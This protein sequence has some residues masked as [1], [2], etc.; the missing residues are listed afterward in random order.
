MENQAQTSVS[1]TPSRSRTPLLENPILDDETNPWKGKQLVFADPKRGCENAW[2]CTPTSCSSTPAKSRRQFL[3]GTLPC[4]RKRAGRKLLASSSDIEVGRLL[5]SGGGGSNIQAMDHDS[6]PPSK[7]IACLFPTPCTSSSQHAKL[8]TLASEN[9]ALEQD[10]NFWR[11]HNVQ[12]IVRIRPLN[13]AETAANGTSTCLRQESPHALTWLGQ[14]ESRFTFDHVACASTSQEQ[15]FQLA[16]LPMVENCIK[17]YNSTIFAY[18]QT[19]SGKT[20]TMLGDIE[21]SDQKLSSDCG[22]TPRIFEYL[23]SRVEM[24]EASCRQDQLIFTCKCSFLEIYNEQITDL[25][26]P[27]STNLQIHENPKKGVYVENLK[28]IEVKNVGDITNLLLQGAANR[29]VAQTRM[30]QESSRSH[31]VFTCVIES[32]WVS[33]SVTN[34]RFGRLNLVDLAGSER[35]KASGAEGERLREAAN[36]N[37]SLSTLGLVIMILVDVA[38]GKQRHVPYRDSKLTFLLQDSL[39]GNSKTTIIATVSPAVSCAN[40]TLSTL[41]FAQRAKFIQNNAIINEDASGDVKALQLQIQDLKKELKRLQDQT[42]KSVPVAPMQDTQASGSRNDVQTIEGIHLEYPKGAEQENHELAAVNGQLNCMLEA[43][44]RDLEYA[45]TM[46]QLKEDKIQRLKRVE[47]AVLSAEN[48]LQEENRALQQEVHLLKERMNQQP[49]L[50][51]FAFENKQLIQQLRSQDELHGKEREMLMGELS[52]LRRQALQGNAM[53]SIHKEQTNSYTQNVVQMKQS[54]QTANSK[55][56]VEENKLMSDENSQA[57]NIIKS[58]IESQG[59]QMDINCLL[60]EG[61]QALDEALQQLQSITKHSFN[62]SENRPISFIHPDIIHRDDQEI[63]CFLQQAFETAKEIESQFKVWCGVAVGEHKRKR[64]ESMKTLPPNWGGKRMRALKSDASDKASE[65]QRENR[66]SCSLPSLTKNC[67]PFEENCEFKGTLKPHE[68]SI[69]ERLPT[70]HANENPS[71]TKE[72]QNGQNSFNFSINVL[73]EWHKT[74]GKKLSN[75]RNKRNIVLDA[76]AMPYSSEAE[77]KQ[78]AHSHSILQIELALASMQELLHIGR[79]ERST[80]NE[81]DEQVFEQLERQLVYM[82]QMLEDEGQQF[83]ALCTLTEKLQARIKQ[84]KSQ[85]V[86]LKRQV[87]KLQ[88][89]AVAKENEIYALQKEERTLAT[90]VEKLHKE[91]E[92]LTT[93]LLCLSQQLECSEKQRLQGEQIYKQTLRGIEENQFQV[94]LKLQKVTAEIKEGNDKFMVV[95]K[96]MKATL[97]DLRMAENTKQILE[98]AYICTKESKGD[99]VSLENGLAVVYQLTSQ[100]QKQLLAMEAEMMSIMPLLEGRLKVITDAW[101]EEKATI[102]VE[103]DKTRLDA[104][105]KIGEASETLERFKHG[106]VIIRE[107]ELMV[108]TLTKAIESAR[109]KQL[110]L[111][112]QWHAERESMCAEIAELKRLVAQKEE[113]LQ[114]KEKALISNNTIMK[115]FDLTEVQSSV[116]EQGERT[117]STPAGNMVD[118]SECGFKD[119]CQ[120]NKEL[121]ARKGDAYAKDSKQMLAEK[122]ELI[123]LKEERCP[124]KSNIRL[125]ETSLHSYESAKAFGRIKNS[126]MVQQIQLDVAAEIPLQLQRYDED[127]NMLLEKL[128]GIV[129]T[130]SQKQGGE[131]AWGRFLNSFAVALSKLEED[132][133]SCLSFSSVICETLDKT[134]A[135]KQDLQE[136][137]KR[138]Q[139]LLKGSFFDLSLLQ[140]SIADY[141]NMKNKLDS[142]Q[143]ELEIKDEKLQKMESD[144]AMLENEQVESTKKAISLEVIILEAEQSRTSMAKKN[145]EMR[146]KMEV[147]DEKIASLKAMLEEQ[148]QANEKLQLEMLDMDFLIEQKMTDSFDNMKEALGLAFDEKQQLKVRLANAEKQLKTA[149]LAADRSKRLADE[150]QQIAETSMRCIEENASELN[151]MERSIHEFERT[152]SVLESQIEILKTEA[153][154]QQLRREDLEMELQALRHQQYHDPLSSS[155]TQGQ[156][157]AEVITLR[158]ELAEKSIEIK[159]LVVQVEELMLAAERQA[160]AHHQKL[161]SLEAMA[162]NLNQERGHLRMASPTTKNAGERHVGNCSTSPFKCINS[163][164]AQQISYEKDEELYL[165]KYRIDELQ[166]LAASRQKE[167]FRLHRKLAEAEAMT[168]DVIRDLLGVK[169]DIATHASLLNHEDVETLIKRASFH[170]RTAKDKEKELEALR[171]EY[172]EEK[173]RW[174]KES[175]RKQAEVLAAHFA[176]EKLRQKEFLLK[177]ENKRLKTD[178]CKQKKR[179]LRLQEKIKASCDKDTIT[180]ISRAS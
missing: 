113:E 171:E 134:L 118:D 39:G 67:L 179:L 175:G 119:V 82:S 94:K 158:R 128:D 170:E 120:D 110:T 152:I 44:E 16:G 165:N 34:F 85:A 174:S 48:C 149:E 112:S 56:L 173:Q 115:T 84:S 150:A 130:L 142:L 148:R 33:D 61:A 40:E 43:Y 65:E 132:A 99:A 104:A 105:E 133:N 76:H 72:P 135:E 160:T 28:E 3:H 109:G 176:M 79:Q 106:H 164:L 127:T 58:G 126:S 6:N 29:R 1:M 62:A 31:G 2:A 10:Q 139:E 121:C 117:H 19:G 32:Q 24:E 155:E 156:H 68:L 20:H 23:F 73:R 38:Q 95:K 162:D 50:L 37:K 9:V 167:I 107:A 8:N 66:V 146:Q 98:E 125:Q 18:G 81:L 137:L 51:R 45:K 140:E 59:D 70:F 52:N 163:G 169:S 147:A 102:L 103:L 87:L 124:D 83:D 12:V 25:L 86:G 89:D 123:N 129:A 96:Q 136:E 154:L 168:Y 5:V 7:S 47:D 17:G 144:Y 13:I 15:L 114:L 143:A 92:G 27:T 131:D 177:G 161:I 36:I 22:I 116:L 153:E 41:K 122:S 151:R 69:D 30:N 88:S 180:I 35:Q 74:G 46:L 157:S 141:Q 80:H 60:D 178:L 90:I 54:D 53:H 101:R 138:K 111:K 100:M 172:N 91:E 145:A 75:E 159:N 26:E 21:G 49:E 64:N 108:N 63:R 4:T 77:A 166:D 57:G 71:F 11:D 42:S 55:R 14:P 93:R 78:R 97:R